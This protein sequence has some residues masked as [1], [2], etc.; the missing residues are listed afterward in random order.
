MLNCTAFA[1]FLDFP[2]PCLSVSFK[3]KKLA[4]LILE[5]VKLIV[6]QIA[7]VDKITAPIVSVDVGSLTFNLTARSAEDYDPHV[8]SRQAY[9]SQF[10]FSILTNT[11]CKLGRHSQLGAKSLSSLTFF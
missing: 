11:S 7:E 4:T 1:A 6:Y 8:G 5:H 10:R 9:L 2:T 3:K